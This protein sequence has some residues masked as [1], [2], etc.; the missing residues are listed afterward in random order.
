MRLLSSG[1]IGGPRFYAEGAAYLC[2][3]H[4]VVFHTR[5]GIRGRGPDSAGGET[6][7][8]TAPL[9]PRP[10]FDNAMSLQEPEPPTDDY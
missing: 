7:P 1:R 9:S 8:V 5:E 6:A 2:R 10:L 4:G 3:S